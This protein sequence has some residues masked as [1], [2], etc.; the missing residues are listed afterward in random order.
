MTERPLEANAD[1]EA[2]KRPFL[3]VLDTNVFVSNNLLQTVAGSALIDL[4]VRGKGRILLPEVI[5]LELK[6]VLGERLTDDAK[7][8]FLKRF[9]KEACS[10]HLT[11]MS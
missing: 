7:K 4:V 1:A 2:I 5:E 11:R 3:V 10:K 9:S 8:A 6:N